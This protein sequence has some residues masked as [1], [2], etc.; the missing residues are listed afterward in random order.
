MNERFARLAVVMA[1]ASGISFTA[2]AQAA[3]TPSTPR[4]VSGTE[5]DNIDA[6]RGTLVMLADDYDRQAVD[7][8]KEAEMYRAWASANDVFAA[9]ASPKRLSGPAFQNRAAELDHAAAESRKL[10]AKYRQLIYAHARA[11]GC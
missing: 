4:C 8:A 3:E 6:I 1:L 9:D 7:Y 2:P 11:Q 5:S 10:A